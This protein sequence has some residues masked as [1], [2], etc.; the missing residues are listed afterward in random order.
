MDSAYATGLCCSS[1][2][3]PATKARY[4]CT[5]PDARGLGCPVSH[6]GRLLRVCGRSLY[7]RPEP[8]QSRP[9]WPRNGR[10]RQFRSAGRRA[11]AS[12]ARDRLPHVEGT[13]RA[14]SR[15][16]PRGGPSRPGHLAL[17]LD[18]RASD[19][20]A[21]SASAAPLA[22]VEAGTSCSEERH[23]RACRG[24]GAPG[25]RPWKIAARGRARSSRKVVPR[26]LGT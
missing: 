10:S 3:L 14:I 17:P 11:G 5:C 24:P 23:A 8:R 21:C 6:C 26:G 19:F 12:R 15:V 4:D 9:G 22:D 18:S 2:T 13:G 1:C 16:G 7:D 25:D 20:L